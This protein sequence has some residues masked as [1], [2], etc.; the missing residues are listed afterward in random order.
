MP[1]WQQTHTFPEV[2]PTHVTFFPLRTGFNH[3]AVYPCLSLCP[4]LKEGA[5]PL[6]TL[7]CAIGPISCRSLEPWC[8]G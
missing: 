4:H 6:L 1:S 2:G 3:F 8:L 5:A 7:L